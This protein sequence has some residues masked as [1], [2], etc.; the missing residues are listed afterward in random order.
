MNSET[1]I[2][3]FEGIQSHKKPNNKN[4]TC[5]RQASLSA[6]A[7]KIQISNP[8]TLNPKQNATINNKL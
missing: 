2:F 5:L 1:Y 8:E 7:D 3:K 6:A 4:Q